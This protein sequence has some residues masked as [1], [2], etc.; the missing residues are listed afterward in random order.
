MAK[1]KNLSA[2][3]SDELVQNYFDQLEGANVFSEEEFK[4][5][6]EGYE[7][8]RQLVVPGDYSEVAMTLTTVMWSMKGVT[9]LDMVINTALSEP[10]F[11]GVL[12][13]FS[14]NRLRE[15]NEEDAILD[16]RDS[17]EQALGDTVDTLLDSDDIRIKIFLDMAVRGKTAEQ[18]AKQ[19]GIS[20]QNVFVLYEVARESVKDLMIVEHD[21]LVDKD[22][23][24]TTK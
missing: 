17:L 13:E 7:C 23:P 3:E 20:T 6:R 19:Y 16:K 22:T 12:S 10:L 18:V 15:L 14:P 21:V 1:N 5:L 8:L 24:K 2:Q 9:D 4:V 11:E